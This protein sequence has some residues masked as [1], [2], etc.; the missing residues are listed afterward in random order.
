MPV[1]R[2]ETYVELARTVVPMFAT[3][4]LPDDPSDA[5]LM[6]AIRDGAKPL[7]ELQGPATAVRDAPIGIRWHGRPPGQRL[8][9]IWRSDIS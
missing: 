7:D 1:E 5:E 8:P 2:L 4:R 3:L 9:R 6:A